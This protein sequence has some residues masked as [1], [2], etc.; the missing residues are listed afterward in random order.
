[1]DTATV[2]APGGGGSY[3]NNKK[4]KKKKHHLHKLKKKVAKR[5]QDTSRGWSLTLGI[6]KSPEERELMIRQMLQ[7]DSDLEDSEEADD[8]EEEQKVDPKK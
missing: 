1:M 3:R 8:Q 6:L 7:T 4:N 5:K 2:V